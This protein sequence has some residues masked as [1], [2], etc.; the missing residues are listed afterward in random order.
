M[1]RY[2]VLSHNNNR[3]GDSYNNKKQ[4]DL[5][6]YDDFRKYSIEEISQMLGIGKTKTRE[7]LQSRLLPVTKVGRDYFT[8]PQAI[9]E[10]LKKTLEKNFIFKVVNRP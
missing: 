9:Q 5:C 8:S 4:L 3:G 2:V 7:L 10:F 1:G 6:Q